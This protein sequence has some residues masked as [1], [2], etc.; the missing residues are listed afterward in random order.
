MGVRFA[1]GEAEGSGEGALERRP[2][3]VP[4]LRGDQTRLFIVGFVFGVFA[5]DGDVVVALALAGALALLATA[6]AV[7]LG[8]SLSMGG[9][10]GGGKGRT[11]KFDLFLPIAAVEWR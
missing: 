7:L 2:E 4:F 6:A 10:K 5:G 9:E 1:P 11:R 8:V 3:V